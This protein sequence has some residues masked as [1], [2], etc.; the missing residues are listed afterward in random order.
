MCWDSVFRVTTC[1]DRLPKTFSFPLAS[2]HLP[3]L[4]A[5]LQQYCGGT[6]ISYKDTIED[7][8]D[9]GEKCEDANRNSVLDKN[10]DQDDSGAFTPS[11]AEIEELQECIKYL[12]SEGCTIKHK[13]QGKN[14]PS[15]FERVFGEGVFQVSRIKTSSLFGK[16]QT[17]EHSSISS[18]KGNM[19]DDIFA[20]DKDIILSEFQAGELM[21]D[22]S[23]AE[24]GSTY[25][26]FARGGS[27]S[28]L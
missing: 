23:N 7:A 2:G 14:T 16:K 27:S 28:I 5:F 26:R 13:N 19:N 4:A 12:S 21:Y 11:D 17:K 8:D 6:H 24:D 9:T 1:C 25:L 20:V 15:L 22:E 3:K 18:G 10:G